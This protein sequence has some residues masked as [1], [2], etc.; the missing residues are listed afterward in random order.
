MDELLYNGRIKYNKMDFRND[1]IDIELHFLKGDTIYRYSGTISSPKSQLLVD[2]KYCYLSNEKLY[3]KKYFKSYGKNILEADFDI[4]DNYHSNVN[5]TSILHKLTSDN[6]YLLN[7][8]AWIRASRISDTF[9]LFDTL[10]INETLMLKL[11]NLFDEGI[12]VFKYDQER[13]LYTI[14]LN[15][16]GSRLYSETEVDALL[17]EGTKR[18]L[19]MFALAIFTLQIG[20]SLLIDEIENSFHK[21]LVEN[22]IMIFNDKRI[23]KNKANLIFSTH[24][25]EILDIFRRRDNIFVMNKEDVITNYNLYVDYDERTDL[26]KSNQFNNNTFKT[27]INYDRLMDLKKELINEV[28]DSSRR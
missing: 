15:G 2:T 27:L 13:R 24:Y 3:S 7:T 14:D 19:I 10:G 20:G 23:N 21:N 11:T 18:G 28:S 6:H 4:N 17:S 16:L 5:D 26:S 8:D 25:V 22:I 12:R 9:A 1:H